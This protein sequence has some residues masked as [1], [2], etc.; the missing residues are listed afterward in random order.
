MSDNK[1]LTGLKVNEISLVDSPAIK[2]EFI[3]TKRDVTKPD[4]QTA[5]TK[6]ETPVAKADGMAACPACGAACAD[7]CTACPTC[8]AAM[9]GAAEPTV[10]TPLL[11]ALMAEKTSLITAALQG[12]LDD[13]S[14][15]E[16]EIDDCR[17]KMWSIQDVMWDM[18]RD[19]AA[20][21]IA[22][23]E[24]G[25]AKVSKALTTIQK[26]RIQKSEAKVEAACA[27]PGMKKFTKAR[28]AKLTEGLAAIHEVLSEV[29][30]ED[31][32]KSFSAL[33]GG[34]DDMS[35]TSTNSVPAEPSATGL[36]KRVDDDLTKMREQVSKAEQATAASAAVAADLQKRLAAIEA[37]GIGKSLG[38][39]AQPVDV[40][41]NVWGDVI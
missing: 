11:N 31:L 36:S 27:Q 32:A 5:V 2:K 17:E 20:V 8:G 33:V 13:V 6:T 19:A 14:S 16:C 22:K 28:V 29:A 39:D 9:G 35:P 10:A 37:V 40:K 3:L 38:T 21:S 41:K 25:P 23:S 26:A 4:G 30:P 7:T 34:D 18:L 15:G 12:L 1:R 24:G